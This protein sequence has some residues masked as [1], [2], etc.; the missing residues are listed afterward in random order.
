M[1]EKKFTMQSEQVSLS[2]KTAQSHFRVFKLQKPDVLLCFIQFLFA[3]LELK[4]YCD[5]EVD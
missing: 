1:S 2:H 5:D 4:I 3:F